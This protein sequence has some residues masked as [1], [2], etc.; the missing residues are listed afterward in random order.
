MKGYRPVREMLVELIPE[1]TGRFR[2]NDALR[3]AARIIDEA[4][5]RSLD[6]S[7]VETPH[8]IPPVLRFHGRREAFVIVYPPEYT[9]Y[10]LDAAAALEYIGSVVPGGGIVIFYT[11]KGRL[12]DVAYLYLGMAI[13]VRELRIL[14]ING[15]LRELLEVVESIAKKGN[16]RSPSEERAVDLGELLE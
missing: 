8:D 15:S 12:T 5:K 1:I 3:E 6:L 2:H 14:F 4:L 7:V 11:R 13:E 9:L 10:S 16:Y